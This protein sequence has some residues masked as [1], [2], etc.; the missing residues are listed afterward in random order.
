MIELVAIDEEHEREPIDD[1]IDQEILWAYPNADR[2][3]CPGRVI[4]EQITERS[5]EQL[6]PP[7][8]IDPASWEHILHCSPCYRE[9]MDARAKYGR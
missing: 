6:I 9:L 3:G 7:R 5:L 1:A 2:V 8:L 4:I